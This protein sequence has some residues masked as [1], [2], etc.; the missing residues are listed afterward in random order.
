MDT[1]RV[2]AALD[3]LNAELEDSD[4]VSDEARQKLQQVTADI[5]QRLGASATSA[6]GGDQSLSGLQEALLEFE[7]D[8]PQLTGAIGQVASALAN[9]GI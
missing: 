4:Q 5:R 7:S 2:L 1:N 3:V 8:H 9:L 6:A